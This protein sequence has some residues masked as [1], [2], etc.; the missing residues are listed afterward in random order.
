MAGRVEVGYL[1]TMPEKEIEG[2]RESEEMFTFHYK[3]VPC[4]RM[5]LV[6]YKG[7]KPNILW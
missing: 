4:A 3:N 5:G 1:T 6:P 7:I 2:E